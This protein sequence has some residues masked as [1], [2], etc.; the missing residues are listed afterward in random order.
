MIS[1]MLTVVKRQDP[2]NT[3]NHSGDSPYHGTAFDGSD[4]PP[5]KDTPQVWSGNNGWK[6][7]NGDAAEPNVQKRPPGQPSTKEMQRV[8]EA[9]GRPGPVAYIQPPKQAEAES[10]SLM[11]DNGTQRPESARPET[12]QLATSSSSRTDTHREEEDLKRIFQMVI[13]LPD[14][15]HRQRV[16]CLD[17]GSDTDLIG[18]QVVESLGLPKEKYR[19]KLL[20]PLGSQYMPDWQVTFDWHIPQFRQ[21][22]YTTTFAVMDEKHSGEFDVLLGRLSIQKIGFYKNNSQVFFIRTADGNI[23]VECLSEQVAPI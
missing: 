10:P 21:K 11:S 13:H 16:T 20:C 8:H 9:A 5:L 1:S 19:G 3:T 2:T 22:T 18:L 14:D 17:T 6:D 23:P 7:A 4:A 12:P 15:E